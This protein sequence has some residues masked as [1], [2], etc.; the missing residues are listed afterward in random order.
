[1]LTGGEVEDAK[2]DASG[3]VLGG[4]GRGAHRWQ[5]GTRC[6]KKRHSPVGRGRAEE[7]GA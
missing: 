6:R 5:G 7:F 2:V 1:V 4:G 3:E